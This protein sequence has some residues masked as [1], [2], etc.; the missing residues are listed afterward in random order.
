MTRE[1]RF[2]E[3]RRALNANGYDCSDLRGLRFT[4]TRESGYA[5]EVELRPRALIRPDNMNIGL[6]VCFPSEGCHYLI[7]HDT[8]VEIARDAGMGVG[9]PSWLR[10]E[11]SWPNLSQMMRY[12]LMEYKIERS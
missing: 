5:I 3:A 10:G 1:E 8:L 6:Y 2:N 4:A 9:T 7:P 11:Y 12:R